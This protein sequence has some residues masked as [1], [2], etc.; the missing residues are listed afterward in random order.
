MGSPGAGSSG[1]HECSFKFLLIGD[2]GVGKSS[3]LVS[4]VA[5]SYLD[6]DI[7]PTIGTPSIATPRHATP[8]PRSA[9]RSL[10]R[11]FSPYH[12]A[13]PASI[14]YNRFRSHH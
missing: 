13:G 12:H 1:G 10:A 9:L 3:L 14:F 6:G 8:L 7:A 4:F 11:C 2:S 5:A